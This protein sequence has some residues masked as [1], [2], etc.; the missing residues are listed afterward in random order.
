MNEIFTDSKYAIQRMIYDEFMTL[1]YHS[2]KINGVNS[3]QHKY[4]LDS[5]MLTGSVAYDTPT[6]QW[7][8][9]TGTGQNEYTLPTNLLCTSGDG[10]TKLHR[11]ASYEPDELGC[12]RITFSP[13][14]ESWDKYTWH[15]AGVLADLKIAILQ[16]AK[17]IKTPMILTTEDK[18]L[19]NSIR[20]AC[21]EKEDGSP[22]VIVNKKVG[23]AL[24]GQETKVTY[25]ADKLLFL[26]D[27]IRSQYLTRIGFLTRVNNTQQR[28]QSAQVYAVVGEAH[29]SIHSYI[30][31]WNEQ[32]E[33]FGL[34]FT[35]ELNGCLDE[36]YTNSL[37]ITANDGDGKEGEP[38]TKGSQYEDSTVSH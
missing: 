18:E 10:K 11:K 1:L 21:E 33:Q 19:V 28:V 16:N 9:V 35:M 25:V 27:E 24:E 8:R 17:A 37:M 5:L 12:Y 32:M 13:T 23:K 4:I 30:D 6:D 26:Y 2:L 3:M 22:T 14:E 34:P 15:M 38:I 36:V 20:L 31:W 7:Y 29:D